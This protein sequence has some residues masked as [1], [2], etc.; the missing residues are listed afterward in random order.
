VKRRSSL[1]NKYFSASTTPGQG[2]QAMDHPWPASY[3]PP[4]FV[5]I[6]ENL[7]EAQLLWK[8]KSRK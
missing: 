2:F 7:A 5:R 8:V 6:V 4:Q 1:I 3:A